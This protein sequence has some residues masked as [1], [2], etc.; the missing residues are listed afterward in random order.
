R[1]PPGRTARHV[2]PVQ[3]AT[4][5]G[6]ERRATVFYMPSASPA[7]DFSKSIAVTRSDA[8]DGP[9][10][11]GQRSSQAQYERTFRFRDSHWFTMARE[12][13]G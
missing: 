4:A 10:G 2:K 5:E 1:H 7:R 13:F 6:A 8:A 3:T 9:H 11:D 12:V